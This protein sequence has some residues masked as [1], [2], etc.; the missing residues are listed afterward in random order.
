MARHPDPANAPVYDLHRRWL[1]DVLSLGD[2]LF[3]P[4]TPVWSVEHLDELDDRFIGHP[5]TTGDQSILEKL[6]SQL[7][8][9]SPGAIQLMAEVH[10][11]HFLIIWKGAVN[12]SGKMRIIETVLSWMPKPAGVSSAIV[13]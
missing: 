1:E 10:L 7:A 13:E 4:G 3:T 6:K 2:S 5:I 8:G 9:A 12:R 11:I